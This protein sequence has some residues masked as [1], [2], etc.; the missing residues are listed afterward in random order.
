MANFFGDVQCGCLLYNYLSNARI[1][2][3]TVQITPHQRTKYTAAL[4]VAKWCISSHVVFW[5][6][7]RELKVVSWHDTQGWAGEVDARTLRESGFRTILGVCHPVPRLR[8]NCSIFHN[9]FRTHTH[10]AVRISAS[11]I[12]EMSVAMPYAKPATHSR[13]N[14]CPTSKGKIQNSISELKCTKMVPFW[15][16]H[17]HMA[18]N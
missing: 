1:Q 17:T 6:L 7:A 2:H 10:M 16:E 5:W 11:V 9:T 18:E 15:A 3:S 13:R 8:R 12:Y 14:T 4:G